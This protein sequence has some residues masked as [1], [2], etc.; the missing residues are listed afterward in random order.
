MSHATTF[1]LTVT[2]PPPAITGL[3]P[4]SGPVG[5]A[6]TIA[7]ANFGATKGTS[8]VAFNGTLATSSSWSDTSITVPLPT[9]ATSGPVVVTVSGQASNG[10]SFTVTTPAPVITSLTPTSGPVGTAVTI[11][12][13][14]FGATA[15]T[16]TR[17]VQRDAGDAEQLEC[18][19]HY[20]AGADGRDDRSRRGDRQRP[21]QQRRGLYGDGASVA[22]GHHRS[23]ADV[24]AGGDGGDDRRREFRRDA[25]H[26]H[27]RVQRDAGDADQLERHEHYRAGADGRHGRSRRGDRRRSGQQ[28]RELYGDHAGAGHHAV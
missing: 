25:G 11:A 16:S 6:V 26:E 9:G 28:R 18:H 8:T 22:A 23:D 4:T 13:A 20:R 5:T 14:N 2:P 21:G 10:V 12:G 27:R 1:T 17:R 3:T 15:G 7:G 24:G 19:E